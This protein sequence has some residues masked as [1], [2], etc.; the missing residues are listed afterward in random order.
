MKKLNVIQE[1]SMDI[2][3]RL[4]DNY[5]DFFAPTSDLIDNAIAAKATD[6]QIEIQISSEPNLNIF[7]ISDN[8]IGFDL[9]NIE[10]SFGIGFTKTK[11]SLNQYGLGLKQAIA[12][13]GRLDY[14]WSAKA[15]KKEGF[16]IFDYKNRKYSISSEKKESFGFASRESGTVIR[17]I[18]VRNGSDSLKEAA[19]LSLYSDNEELFN[20]NIKNYILKLEKTYSKLTN[21]NVIIHLKIK[22]I[23]NGETKFKGKLKPKFQQGKQFFSKEINKKGKNGEIY[24]FEIHCKYLE[25]NTE[26]T[27][28]QRVVGQNHR[29]Y[30]FREKGFFPSSN[31]EVFGKNLKDSAFVDSRIEVTIFDAP[32]TLTPTKDAFKQDS[33][34][35]EFIR[36]QEDALSKGNSGLLPSIDSMNKDY[37]SVYMFLHDNNKTMYGKEHFDKHQEILSKKRENQ[38]EKGYSVNTASKI[39]CFKPDINSS[40]SKKKRGRGSNSSIE[41]LEITEV[42]SVTAKASDLHQLLTYCLLAEKLPENKNK[43]IIGTILAPNFHKDLVKN[44]EEFNSQQ[45]FLLIKLE[46]AI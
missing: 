25:K 15:D 42:K 39:F 12:T 40:Y 45:D 17:I 4:G 23:D 30:Y 2:V 19:G 44:V 6:I 5:K 33:Y 46:K 13:L 27:A 43:K 37:N 20:S 7:Q 8:G 36:L 3:E 31:D 11:N 24:H 22:N 21:N 35:E 14:L 10:E 28:F 32:L 1:V 26:D 16:K 9:K 29:A 41:V 34:F 18:G 38:L